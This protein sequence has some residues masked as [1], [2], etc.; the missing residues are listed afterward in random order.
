MDLESFVKIGQFITTIAS[1]TLIPLVKMIWSLNN[2]MYEIE[3]QLTRLENEI[4]HL[5]KD[6]QNVKHN[7]SF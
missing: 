3:K 2:R 7:N 5:T 6:M 4:S 1:L